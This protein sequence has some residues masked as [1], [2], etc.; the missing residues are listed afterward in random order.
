DTPLLPTALRGLWQYYFGRAEFAIAGELAEQVVA[1]GASRGDDGLEVLGHRLAGTTWFPVGQFASTH[2]HLERAL[3]LYDPTR[4]R[5]LATVSGL[6]CGVAASIYLAWNHWF[7]GSSARAVALQEGAV[8]QALRIGDQHTL[9]FTYC[10]ASA[11]RQSRREPAEA[12]RLAEGAAAVASEYGFALWIALS[13]MVR[14]WA[15]VRQ[16]AGHKGLAVVRRGIDRW[17]ATGGRT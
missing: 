7:R 6:D 10:Y 14:G 2:A 12:R 4:H 15:M 8:E 13:D 17:C 1:L 5:G 11:V 9:A 16:G 3:A